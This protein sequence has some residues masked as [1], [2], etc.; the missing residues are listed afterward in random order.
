MT[1]KKS[2]WGGARYHPPGREGGRPKE[3]GYVKHRRLRFLSEDE[4]QAI[5]KLT[6]RQIVEILIERIESQEA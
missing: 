3:N 2:T 4:E 5:R 1:Q 6:P